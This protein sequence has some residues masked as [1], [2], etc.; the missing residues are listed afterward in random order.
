MR[1]LFLTQSRFPGNSAECNRRVLLARLFSLNNIEVLVCGLGDYTGDQICNYKGVDYIS[2]RSNS[3]SLVHR[4]WDRLIINNHRIHDTL[5]KYGPFDYIVVFGCSNSALHRLKKYA[6]IHKVTLVHDSVEWYV[7]DQLKGGRWNPDFRQNQA[8]NTKLIDNRFKV[9]AISRFLERNFQNRGIET[10]YLPA[11]TNTQTSSNIKNL[12]ENLVEIIYAGSPGKKDYLKTVIQSYAMID[13][14]E[15]KKSQLTLIG[16]NEKELIEICE[17]PMEILD[18][19]R[20][21]LVIKGRISHED[22]LSEYQKANFSILIRPE[23][24]IYAKAGFPTKVPESLA[25]GTPVI[26]NLTSDLGDFLVDEENALIAKDESVESVKD[27]LQRA[28]HLTLEQR[29]HM[30]ACARKTAE[31]CFDYRLYT[32]AMGDFLRR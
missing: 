6:K 25:T 14:E 28:I 10:L 2:L 15:R 22:V 19:V 24:Q 4:V 30:C 23:N 13:A 31:D 7:P 21:N 11:V 26:C 27:V 18:S 3:K 20:D 29:E 17:V 9:I 8:W 16:V 1:A 5:K 32:K 12:D